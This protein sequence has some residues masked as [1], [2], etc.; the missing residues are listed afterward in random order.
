MGNIISADLRAIQF[1]TIQHIVSGLPFDP[2]FLISIGPGPVA[3]GFSPGGSTAAYTP[4]Y[5]GFGRHY[6]KVEDLNCVGVISRN[7]QTPTKSSTC[8]G[9]GTFAGTVNWGNGNFTRFC[10]TLAMSSGQYSYYDHYWGGSV[11]IANMWMAHAAVGGLPNF[12]VANPFHLNGPVWDYAA[13]GFRP[14]GFLLT[15]GILGSGTKAYPAIGCSDGVSQWA[16]CALGEP[17]KST[18]ETMNFKS[19]LRTDLCWIW[20]DGLYTQNPHWTQSF[21]SFDDLGFNTDVVNP[22]GQLYNGCLAVGGCGFKCGTFAKPTGAAG[23]TTVLTPG[24]RPRLI[25]L[26]SQG[27]PHTNDYIDDIRWFQGLAS[28]SSQYS[29]SMFVKQGYLPQRSQSYYSDTKCLSLIDWDSQLLS[30]CGAA[31]D[32]SSVTVTWSTNDATAAEVAYFIIGDEPVLENNQPM[33]FVT[34]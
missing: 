14:A 31:F 27:A 24:F 25:Y 29:T 1:S 34:T 9:A 23:S 30:Q 8:G 10:D 11:D 3:K 5:F 12:Y 7:T 16:F 17:D 32:D 15:P 4:Q 19:I 2:Q 21:N 28:A 6:T 22:W 18:P 13:M 33:V 26:L 20:Q